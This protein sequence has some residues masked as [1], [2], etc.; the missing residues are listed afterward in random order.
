MRI[1]NDFRTDPQRL[2]LPREGQPN[3]Q[4]IAAPIAQNR[5]RIEQQ[6]VFAEAGHEG[7]QDLVIG[8]ELGVER[9][10]KKSFTVC[11]LQHRLRSY[12]ARPERATN[13]P[14][15]GPQNPVIPGH[16]DASSAWPETWFD[17]EP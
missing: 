14:T 16:W 5:Q 17:G 7:W 6:A 12:G 1:A 4:T 13:L 15:R 11:T 9:H 3:L 10:R 2:W 8:D